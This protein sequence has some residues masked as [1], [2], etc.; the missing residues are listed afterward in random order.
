MTTSRGIGLNNGC[1]AKNAAQPGNI[2]PLIPQVWEKD[3]RK[4]RRFVGARLAEHK[5]VIR[6]E[7]KLA[8]NRD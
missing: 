4:Q 7:G 3:H 1:S 8:V 2:N 5:E 6:L